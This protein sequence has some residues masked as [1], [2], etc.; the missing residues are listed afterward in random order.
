MSV[1]SYTG[2]RYGMA[3]KRLP[4]DVLAYFR[5][6]GAKGGR[7]GGKRSL[8][9]MTRPSGAPEP[10]RPAWR[11]LPSDRRRR[12]ASSG[13]KGRRRR[14]NRARIRGARAVEPRLGR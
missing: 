1:H 12:R 2:L 6:M 4:A 7:I 11:L 9:T 5:Q 14:R 10:R 8:E 13:S 3:K